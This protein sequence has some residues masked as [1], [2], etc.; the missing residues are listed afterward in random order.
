MSG[1]ITEKQVITAVVKLLRK[2]ETELPDDVLAAL[3][4]A[5]DK[6]SNPIARMQLSAII[7]NADFAK[8]NVIPICQDTGVPIF[9][10]DVGCEARIN[11][12]LEEVIR[13]GAAK[14][15]E[16]IPLRPNAVHP[17]TRESS[18]N[19]GPGFP[20]VIFDFVPGKN[21]KITVMPKG[22]GSENMSALRMFTPSEVD[23]VKRFVIE[24]VKNAGGMPCP[25]VIVGVGIGG[26][27]DK[28]ARLAKK[29]ALRRLDKTPDGFEQELLE[30]INSLGIGPMGIGGDTTA[31]KVNVECAHCHVASLPVAINIQCWAARRA[32]VT[33]EG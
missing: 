10:V 21:V 2:A 27:F 16:E 15:T 26:T 29:A 31:L 18:G 22:G 8:E 17:L 25:P 9:F 30:A 4:A 5:R 12:D 33:L 6:E 14:A 23:D 13:K 11:F 19:V 24:T 3:K 28:A 7:K 1:V 20:D 32:T